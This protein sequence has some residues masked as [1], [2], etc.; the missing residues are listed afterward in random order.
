[1]IWPWKPP[2]KNPV[3]YIKTIPAFGQ[4]FCRFLNGT[5]NTCGVY[6]RRPFECQLYPFILSVTADAVG[7]Y[8]H[9]GC[10]FVQDQERT[11]NYNAY[12]EYLKG[13][14]NR[15]EVREFLTRNKAM[16]HDYSFYVP[17]LLHVF[18]LSLL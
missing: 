10:P 12:V 4:H 2:L 1:M 14:F 8:V 5:D 17:E 15:L 16:F 9:L 11:E 7:V 13:F 6:A 18:D 3:R